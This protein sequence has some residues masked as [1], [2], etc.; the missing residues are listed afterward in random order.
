[1]LF[2]VKVSRLGMGMEKL[3][4]ITE[5]HLFGIT[6]N[7]HLWR[8]NPVYWSNLVTSMKSPCY[9]SLSPVVLGL[10]HSMFSQTAE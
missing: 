9:L 10:S 8:Y 7:G 6:E 2:V 1:M 3:L 5:R 4:T